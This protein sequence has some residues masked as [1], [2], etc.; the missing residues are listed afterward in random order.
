MQLYSLSNIAYY[1][2]HARTHA[3]THTLGRREEGMNDNGNATYVNMG[4]LRR[5]ERKKGRRDYLVTQRRG[6]N[7]GGSRSG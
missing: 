2:Q 3:H 1:N 5:L 6:D 7:A 4:E